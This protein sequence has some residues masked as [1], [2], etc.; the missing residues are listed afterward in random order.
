M[1]VSGQ[2]VPEVE[3]EQPPVEPTEPAI[4]E[5]T[6]NQTTPT[7]TDDSQADISPNPLNGEAAPIHEP[8]NTHA[9]DG[10]TTSDPPEST[11]SEVVPVER[12]VEAV[13]PPP[14]VPLTLT[15]LYRNQ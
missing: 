14:A 13:E 2:P 11:D 10:L 1:D 4:G 5:E 3:G 6:Q 15:P 12:P 9:D 8:P 7:V